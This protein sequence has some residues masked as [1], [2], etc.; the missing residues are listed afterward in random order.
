M[1]NNATTTF[2]LQSYGNSSAFAPHI[3]DYSR[4][5][6]ENEDSAEPFTFQDLPIR[7]SPAVQQINN[8]TFAYF[9][10][11]KFD[12]VNT[13]T[14]SSVTIPLRNLVVTGD[15][16]NKLLSGS[17]NFY[18]RD[19][20]VGTWSLT[21]INSTAITFDLSPVN[22]SES[23]LTFNFTPI[24]LPKA[25]TESGNPVPV[26]FGFKLKS[27]FEDSIIFN[28]DSFVP[29]ANFLYAFYIPGQGSLDNIGSNYTGNTPVGLTTSPIIYLQ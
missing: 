26:Y 16:N 10:A 19:K 8:A 27:S 17:Y 5:G 15:V 6:A 9:F 20:L 22:I 28:A 7:A 13:S 14:V 23:Y 3:I 25:G 4:Y 1:S 2:K 21:A 29:D 11:I 24:S 18:T 12:Q